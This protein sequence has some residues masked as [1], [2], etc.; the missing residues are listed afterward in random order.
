MLVKQTKGKC[1]QLFIKKGDYQVK[2]IAF[3]DFVFAFLI[4]KV[5]G[6]IRV[7]PIEWSR[8]V[9]LHCGTTQLPSRGER[10]LF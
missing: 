1:N 3:G 4:T 10:E 9:A 5:A 2:G 7:A 6:K 8:G